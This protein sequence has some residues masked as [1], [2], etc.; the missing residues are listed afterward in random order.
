MSTIEI[1]TNGWCSFCVRAK[2][3]LDSKGVSYQEYPI[4]LDP[5]KRAE[6]IQ[7]SG[8]MTVPQIFIDGTH[9]GGSDDLARAERSGA[10]DRLL[11]GADGA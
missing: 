3:L 7:R 6:M 10:L 2:R 5:E 8:R 11:G 1:Y 9:V 4:D